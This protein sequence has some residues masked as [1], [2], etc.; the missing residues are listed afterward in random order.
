MAI[1]KK[2]DLLNANLDLSDNVPAG[3]IEGWAREAELFD[4]RGLISSSTYYSKFL[5]ETAKDPIDD[6][7]LRVL[8]PYEFVV[9]KNTYR[10]EGVKLVLVYF[11]YARF[12]KVGTVKSSTSGIVTKTG[13][14]TV[15]VSQDKIFELVNQYRKQASTLWQDIEFYLDN[16]VEDYNRPGVNVDQ[17]QG[18]KVQKIAG[19]TSFYDEY[20]FPYVYKR[21]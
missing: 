19:P 11:T 3:N 4:L 21:Y 2:Q 1:V 12:L 14:N 20:A 8:N 5:I 16:L 6:D 18:L 13:V 15:P 9:D 10:H 7:Y 17:D